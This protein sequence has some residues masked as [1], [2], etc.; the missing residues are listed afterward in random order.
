MICPN[1]KTENLDNARFCL[2][3]GVEFLQDT[4]PASPAPA[5]QEFSAPAPAVPVQKTTAN[6]VT[7]NKTTLIIII[8]IVSLLIVGLGILLVVTMQNDSP[9]FFNKETITDADGEKIREGIGTTEMSVMDVD[10]TVRTIKTDRSLLTHDKI[11]SEYTLVMNQL[12]NDAPGFSFARYQNLP[13]DRQN[14][15]PAATIVLP[16]IE[17]YVT[18]KSASTPITYT[19]GNADKLPLPNSPY[20]CMLKDST[21]IKN[22][23]CEVMDSDTHK[24]VM[25]LADELNPQ[26]N[27]AD[28]TT[29]QSAI[30]AVFD[31]YDAATQITA[32]SELAFNKIDFNYTDCTVTLLYD[33]DSK[34]VQSISMT[35]NIDITANTFIGKLN[36][37]IVDVCEY[38]QITY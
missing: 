9:G 13:T 16:I 37:R 32:I 2:N 19:A 26:I 25:T 23:Y 35:M 30:T 11:L 24:I 29:S 12:K 7:I 3:C 21:K 28:A 33:H 34:Q 20:G 6:N 31:P 22:A 18:S 10:G 1:C 8:A 17:K 36:A 27:T 38:T 5:A 4:R 14:V 15:G